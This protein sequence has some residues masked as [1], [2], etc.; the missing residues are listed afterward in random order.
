MALFAGQQKG[1][2]VCKIA[3]IR[4]PQR[5]FLGKPTETQPNLE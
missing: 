2:P 1:H 5:L 4:N 3:G